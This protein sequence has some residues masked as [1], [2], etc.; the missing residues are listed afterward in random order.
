M[1]FLLDT[2]NLKDIERYSYYYPI[3]GVTTNPS[4]VKQEGD[5][6]FFAHMKEIRRIIGWDKTL[7]IQVVATDTAG[8]LSDA[9]TI[10]DKI[11]DKVFIKVPTTEEGLRAMMTLKKEGIGVTA[12]AIYTKIQGYMAIQAGADYVAAYRNR[13]ESLDINFGE[14]ITGFRKM[15][16]DCHLNTKIL[17]A[18][19]KNISQV[20]R[21][22]MAGAHTATVPPALLHKAFQM[23]MVE[24]AVGDFESDWKD[25][26]GNRTIVDLAQEV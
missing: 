17:A 25:V 21:A 24:Q 6:D 4:I 20:N 22:F 14:A 7:H 13:M 3:I 9:Y 2:A 11:D 10:L 16:D 19:F 18:S 5:I 23:A 12:T 8:M 26:Y 1:A 15:I